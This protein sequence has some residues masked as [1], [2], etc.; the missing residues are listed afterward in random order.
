MD[1]ML[2]LGFLAGVLAVA[3]VIMVV[4]IISAFIA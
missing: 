2:F 3:I 1:P 4:T